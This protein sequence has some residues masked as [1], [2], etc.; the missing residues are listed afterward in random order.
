M[1][2]DKTRIHSNPF[3]GLFCATNDT[4][5]LVPTTIKKTEETKVKEVLGTEVFKT[6]LQGST[7]LGVF[8]R[9]NNKAFIISDTTRQQD[10]QKLLDAGIK[11][12]ALKLESNAVGN[13]IAANDKGCL[14]SPEI[15]SSAKN[16]EKTL[17]VPVKKLNVAGI[18]LVGSSIVCTNK[19][20]II[21][22]NAS[23]DEF[24]QVKKVLGVNGRPTTANFGDP[25]LAHSILVNKHGLLIGE[26]TSG[27]EITRITNGLKA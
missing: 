14:I 17:G 9:G 2:V 1:R 16:I 19:G 8:I 23:E 27:P 10:V 3:I 6:T 12:K 20:F 22:P 13:L 25:L 26:N 18:S 15:Q 24:N 11:V 7:L 5:T 21:N 4:I